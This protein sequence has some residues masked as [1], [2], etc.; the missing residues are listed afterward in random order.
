M[1]LQQSSVWKTK[2]FKIELLGIAP[3]ESKLI[4][5]AAFAHFDGKAARRNFSVKTAFI[6]A[7]HGVKRLRTICYEPDKN[8]QPA[9]RTLRVGEADDGV[10]Q[11]DMFEQFDEINASLFENCAAF[12]AQL[13]IFK[14]FKLAQDRLVAPRQKTGSNPIGACP[15]PQIQTRGLKLGRLN[16]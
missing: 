16:L 1:K 14:F 11:P 5:A 10:L 12:Q 2:A 3:S 8:I 4:Q 6:A 15:E 13:I 7:F 9:G